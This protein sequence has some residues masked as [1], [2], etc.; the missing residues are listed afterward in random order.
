MNTPGVEQNA[1][2]ATALNLPWASASCPAATTNVSSAKDLT[3]ALAA[4]QP[5][6]VIQL[7]PGTYQGNFVAKSSGTASQ[8]IWL[9][10]STGAILDGGGTS[11]GYVFH[12]DHASYWHL[13]GFAAQ[14]GQKGV[15]ADGST[16]SVIQ[17]LQVSDV[18][19]EGIH[20]R[21]NSTGNVVVGNTVHDTGKRRDKFGEGIYVGTA[22]S[23][24][25]TVTNCQPDRSD[26]NVIAQNTIS[27]T[28]A[29]NVDIKEGTTG[30]LLIKNKFDGTGMTA[31]DSLIDVK[32]TAWA[33]VDNTGVNAPFDGFQ[34]HQ[35][36]DRWGERNLFAGNSLAAGPVSPEVQDQEKSGAQR[37]G[38]AF[39]PS[40][41]N[42][43]AC[44]NTVTG[45]TLATISCSSSVPT[46]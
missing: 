31:A 39:R 10:G 1:Q 16:G 22:V 40:G 29:E 25:C 18:G 45:L 24:W 6:E 13:V 3:T 23:N 2:P 20:L 41:G 35:I 32:G 28:T 30:G 26:G 15:V 7:A 43:L 21:D 11:G 46:N 4:A 9:C 17:G 38:F 5:G 37:Y 42:L 36:E 33:V 12:L 44:N 34:T 27:A 8:P 14:N 19:D